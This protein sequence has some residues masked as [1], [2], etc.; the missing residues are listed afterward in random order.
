MTIEI[1]MD[2]RVVVVTGATG[3]IGQG[4]V[5]RFADAGAAVVVHYR[6]DADGAQHLADEVG[7]SAIG[8]D[9]ATPEGPA[10][11]LRAVIERYER[12]DVL[13]NNA[14]TQAS[15]HLATM[16]DDEWATTIGTNVTAVHR[17]TRAA[18]AAMDDGGSIIHIASIEGS[19]PAPGHGH[20]AVSKAAVIMHAKAAAL[21]WGDR[22]IRVNAVSPGLI[23]RP[24]LADDWP[25]GVARWHAAAPLER[26]GTPA[27]V[28]AA[29]VFL[30]S[31][32][33]AWITGIN[34]VVDGGVSAGPTW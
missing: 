26:L 33:A 28:G 32:L 5:R 7:G 12:I 17:L 30:A 8:A 4:I 22:G 3:G 13:V 25:D 1:D 24:G 29:C 14:A 20:Y 27:D 10:T 9:L 31:D 18:A 19:Q 6:S 11:L 2:G 34:L 15:A 16:S 23:D 21:E